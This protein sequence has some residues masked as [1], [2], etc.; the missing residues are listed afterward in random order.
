M[1]AEARQ[2]LRSHREALMERGL[3]WVAQAR[4]FQRAIN[5]V[6]VLGGGFLLALGGGMDGPLAP[7]A[8]V[9]ALTLKGLCIGA[10]A[11]LVFIG[12]LILLFL[13][14]EAPKLL[15]RASDLER[16]AQQYLD[17]RDAL[18]AE[19]SWQ[20]ALDKRRLALIDAN[21]T[22][23]ETLEQALLVPEAD[24]AGTLEVM[25]DA[26]LRFILESIGLEHSEAWAISVFKIQGDRLVRIAAKRADRLGERAEARSWGRNEGFVGSAWH[27]N[28]DMVIEDGMEPQVALDYPVPLHMRRDNDHVR[29]RSMAAIP[30]RLGPDSTVWGVVAASTDCA[31]R[32]RREPGNRQVQAVDTVRLIARMTALMAAAFERSQS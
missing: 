15:A 17:E 13:Q 25:L 9:G 8:G 31:G 7:E 12:S 28:R 24:V 27:N 14:D 3:V 19:R 2:T 26:S 32:F 1:Q 18:L 23:R 5:V 22:M 6:G 4:G 21:K 10:G 20:D 16:E 11:V 29:Y 30:V